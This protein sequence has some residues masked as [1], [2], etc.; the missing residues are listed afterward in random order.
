MYAHLAELWR[1]YRD[2]VDDNKK[3]PSHD[4][5]TTFASM[6]KAFETQLQ[7]LQEQIQFDPLIR[8]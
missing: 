2:L 7:T 5:L 3:G 8:N 4:L 6:K 1:V